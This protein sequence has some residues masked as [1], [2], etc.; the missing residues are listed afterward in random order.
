[1]S[2]DFSIT[3][4]KQKICIKEIIIYWPLNKTVRCRRASLAFGLSYYTST[5]VCLEHLYIRDPAKRNRWF[6]FTRY[7]DLCIQTFVLCTI[8]VL[9]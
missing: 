4:K 5:D 2:P 8:C 9:R 7:V 1:M 3:L 6:L